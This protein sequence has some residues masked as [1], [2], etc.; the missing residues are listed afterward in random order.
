MDGALRLVTTMPTPILMCFSTNIGFH[1]LLQ[2]PVEEP[3]GNC[4]YL[5]R[6]RWGTCAHFLLRNDGGGKLLDVAP[7]TDVALSEWLPPQSLDASVFNDA[8]HVPTGPRRV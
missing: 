5:G 3:R 7:V 6:F 2:E 1:P 4:E 8:H